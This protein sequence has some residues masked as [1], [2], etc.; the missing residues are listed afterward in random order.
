[1]TQDSDLALTPDTELTQLQFKDTTIYFSN[2]QQEEPV[3][4]TTL[5]TTKLTSGL[6]DTDTRSHTRLAMEP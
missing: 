2:A 5:T 1:M 3:Q 4:V 6:T